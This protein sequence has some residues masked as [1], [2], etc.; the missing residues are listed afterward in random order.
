MEKQN[1]T[2]VE[3]PFIGRTDGVVFPGRKFDKEEDRDIVDYYEKDVITKTGEGEDDYKVTKKVVEYSRV[4][5]DKY[6]QSFSDEV[7]IKNILKKVALGGVDV[8]QFKAKPGEVDLTKFPNGVTEAEQL[9]AHRQEIWDSLP[10]DLKAKMTYKE[11]VEDESVIG[12]IKDY[13]EKLIA[14]KKVEAA[15]KKE[16]EE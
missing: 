3:N 4:N 5:R 10:D 16:G 6:I 14:L 8:E 15:K 2:C 1:K 11:F 7:G 13:Y 9:L 12:T